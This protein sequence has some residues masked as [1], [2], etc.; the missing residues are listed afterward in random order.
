MALLKSKHVLEAQNAENS[1][2]KGGGGP[3]VS[4]RV[5]NPTGGFGGGISKL[6]PL[7]FVREI[8]CGEHIK[9]PF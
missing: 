8:C 6:F 2:K 5:E 1:Q 9:L 4:E 3:Q 7:S